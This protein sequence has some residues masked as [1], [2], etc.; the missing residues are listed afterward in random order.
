MKSHRLQPPA[1]R[2][3]KSRLGFTLIELLVVISIIA[4]LVSLISPA[5]QSAREAA[6]RTQCLNNIRNL[7]LACINFA[8]G[9]GDKYPLLESS[10]FTPGGTTAPYGTR[11]GTAGLTPAVYNGGMSWAAQIVG[12]LDEPAMSRLIIGNGGIVNP[13]TGA[14]FMGTGPNNAIPVKSVFTCPDDANNFG[15]S[16]GLSYVANAGYIN[17]T[18]WG[19]VN[20]ITTTLNDLGT[21]AHDSTLIAWS[22]MVPPGTGTPTDVPATDEAVAHA[23]GVFWRNDSSGF[24]MTQDYI[25]R[26]DG[27]THT[28][29]LSENV[30]AGFWA[31]YDNT[32]RRDLQT[33]YIAFG[34]SVTLKGAVPNQVATAQSTGNFGMNWPTT[35][36]ATNYYLW[37]LPTTQAGYWALVDAS[38]TTGASTNDADMNSNLSTAVN[39]KTA[40]PSSNHPNIVLFCFADG[41]ALPLSQNIDIG[42]YMRAISPGGS[43]FQQPVDG[44]VK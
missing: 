11:A 37:A 10:L 24:T 19:N 33:G 26:A 29:L 2:R 5:V 12:Y 3:A 38:T 1:W 21:G 42:V 17:N 9:N 39:G 18:S 23:T 40:R 34:V 15:I 35:N 36:T 27:S 4:V 28:F 20:P 7:G 30:N 32:Q 13:A 41:H 6:R 43:L 44:D 25:Q 22:Q 14:P 16:G 31:D 8:G